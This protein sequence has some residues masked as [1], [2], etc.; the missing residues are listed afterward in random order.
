MSAASGSLALLLWLRLLPRNGPAAARGESEDES[1]AA[2]ADGPLVAADL[3]HE[4]VVSVAVGLDGEVAFPVVRGRQA[5][6]GRGDE[7]DLAAR[8][9]DRSGEDR[10]IEYIVDSHRPT[11]VGAGVELVRL[12]L[13][14]VQGHGA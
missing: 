3:V 1:V 11:A 7:W 9:L 5:G 13:S 8:A 6:C 10:L 4:Q 14:E 2:A 12:A